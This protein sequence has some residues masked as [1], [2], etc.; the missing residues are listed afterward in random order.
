M[1][2]YVFGTIQSDPHWSSQ[3]PQY[4]AHYSSQNISEPYGRLES[5][6]SSMGNGP[7]QPSDQNGYSNRALIMMCCGQ[8]GLLLRPDQ[9]VAAIDRYFRERSFLDKQG[10]VGE[11]YSTHSSVGHDFLTI[12]PFLTVVRSHFPNY[13]IRTC[14]TLCRPCWAVSRTEIVYISTVSSS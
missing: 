11:V 12:W 7:V 9:N 10:P 1:D 6:I 4:D 5:A 8:S 3:T 14:P 2:I 13:Q